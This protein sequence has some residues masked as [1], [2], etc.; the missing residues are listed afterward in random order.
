MKTKSIK[1][2]FK[3]LAII[4]F[5]A[6]TFQSCNND[7][8]SIELGGPVISEFEYGEGHHGEDE[9]HDHEEEAYAYKGSD[10]HLEA[11][12][13]SDV[14]IASIS[15]SVH[16]HDVEPGDDEVEWDF[17]KVFTDEKYL[18]LNPTFHEHIDIPSNIPAGEY[19]VELVVTDEDGKST[20]VEGHVDIMEPITISEPSVDTTVTRGDDFHAEFMINAVKGIHNVSVDVHAHG[21]TVAEGEVEWDFEKEFED[22]YHEKTEVEFHEHI[23]VPA[24]APA[25]EY[26]IIFTV[27]D[28]DGNT[29]KYETHIDVTKE[30]AITKA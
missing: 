22:K 19:H 16:T 28:E 1:T 7:D 6:L 3:F 8:D 18:V 30:G 27:K 25:G 5:L 17:E 11:T 29:Q 26:H 23:D 21:L 20:E 10:M 14:K 13:T 15:L 4:A 2:N 24:T 9:D 12:I